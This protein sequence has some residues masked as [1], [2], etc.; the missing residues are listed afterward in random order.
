MDVWFFCKSVCKHWWALMSCAAF[1]FLGVYV[2]YTGRSNV[3]IV[4][5]SF[6]FAGIA[7][8]VACFLAWR[9]ERHRALKA[10]MALEK[11]PV[12]SDDWLRLSKDFDALPKRISVQW[13]YRTSHGKGEQEWRQVADK[14]CEALCIRGGLLLQKLPTRV[15]NELC[16]KTPNEADPVRLWLQCLAERG[17][18]QHHGNE[19]RTPLGDGSYESHLSGSIDEL[20]DKSSV[21]CLACANSCD[22]L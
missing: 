11:P 14:R 3:W 15:R 9:E 1:T 2:A 17:D 16:K 12:N 5:C 4:R 19:F 20:G 10:E 6:V 13:A 22:A 7:L 21:L 8:F 18:L